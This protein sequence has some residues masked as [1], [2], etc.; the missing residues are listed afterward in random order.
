MSSSWKSVMK[1]SSMT[2]ASL[3]GWLAGKHYERHWSG[4]L[5][6]ND[7]RRSF[8]YGTNVKS[9]PGLPIFGTVSAAAPIHSADEFNEMGPKLSVSESRISQIMKYGFPGLDNIRSYDDFVLSYDRRNRVAHWVFEHL[10]KESL[11]KNDQ[12]DRSKCEFVPDTS[13][14]PFF[15]SQ[16]TDYK[17]SGYDRGHLAAAG[18]HRLHQKHI[19]QTFYLTNMAP[20]VGA[21]FNRSSW[22]RLEIYVRSLTNI[23]KDVY[24]CTGPLYLPKVESDGK[25]YV[26]YEVIGSN[27]VAVP[28]HFYKIIVG[29]TKDLKL[30]MEAFVMPNAPIDDDAPLKNF[31]VPPESV[32][33]AAGLLFFD[34][35]SKNK[36]HKINGK[37]IK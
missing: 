20:Q 15:R 17:K 7:G 31:Q 2:G 1:L 4:S 11:K 18:N 16:N 13:I 28:T 14:H 22:N 30:E 8:L 34:K 21:G 9:F 33:R 32:E 26:R 25:K 10:T 12:I 27:H 24:V 36:L 23:Y 37:S 5:G 29:E 19:Q 35:L 6:K 3:A